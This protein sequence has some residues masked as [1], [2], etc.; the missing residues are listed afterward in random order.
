MMVDQID[1]VS[2]VIGIPPHVWLPSTLGRTA[3]R[4]FDAQLS[5]FV[6][7]YYLDKLIKNISAGDTAVA[8]QAKWEPSTWPKEAKGVGLMEAPRGALG[9]WVII[10]N[11]KIDNYQCVVPTTWNACPR[12]KNGKHGPYEASMID[13]KVK[14]ADKPLEVQ[15]VI[16]SFDPCLACAAHVY[17]A[18]GEEVAVVR[19]DSYCKV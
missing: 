5:S 3:A 12:D 8:N 11:G 18:E 4:A 17:N 10:K 19:S 7:K 14:I 2:Q 9:H 16:H 1:A 15:K 6:N 13:T